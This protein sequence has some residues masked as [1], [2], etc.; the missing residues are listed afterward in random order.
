VTLTVTDI[1]TGRTA[2]S[3]VIISMTGDIDT[4]RDGIPDSS[5][6]C[7]LVYA[8]TPTGCPLIATYIDK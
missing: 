3:T 4:D 7:P 2:L 8:L 1:V 5:D 6:S